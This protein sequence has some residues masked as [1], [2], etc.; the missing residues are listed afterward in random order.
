MALD[1]LA[2]VAISAHEPLEIGTV[3]LEPPGPMQ[4]LIEVKATS[5][6]HS[7]LHILDG[8]RSARFP[9]ILGH[10][11]AGIVVECGEGVTTLSPG[12]HVVPFAVPQCNDCEYCASRRTNLCRQFF[13]PP[14]GARFSRDGVPVTPFVNLAT[15]AQYTVIPAIYLVKVRKD[16]PLDHICTIGCGIAT[17]V[18]AVLRSAEVTPGATVAIFG[19][20]GIG[21]SAIQGARIAGAKTI[22]GID[23]NPQKEAIARRLGLTHFINPATID[24]KVVEAITDLTSGGADFTFECVGSIKLMVQALESCHPGWGVATVVGLASEGQNI[25]VLPSHL[26]RGRRLIGTAMGGFRGVEGLTQLIDLYMDGTLNIDDMLS[27]TIPL[28]KI[29][30]G[31]DDMRRGEGVRSVVTF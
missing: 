6:C 2:A 5:L 24:G 20:G 22:I 13:S 10:E 27:R 3:Q 23:T 9:I 14:A 26:T 4:V 25:P 11:A 16:A 31:F 28:A 21:L 7:D 12:D 15:F 1:V 18:G 8:A 17:G 30:D 19:L 29:N